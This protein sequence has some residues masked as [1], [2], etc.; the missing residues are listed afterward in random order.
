MQ[1][2]HFGGRGWGLIGGGLKFSGLLIK[3]FRSAGKNTASGCEPGWF[4][5][6]KSCHLFHLS[7]R[8]WG[9]ARSLCHSLGAELAVVNDVNTLQDLANQRREIKL[10]DRDFYLGL[11]GQLLWIWS[12]GE[13]VSNTHNLWGPNQPS[14]DGK[15]GTFLNAIRWDSNW[16]GYGWRWND[17][18]CTNLKGYIC[19]QPL[20]MLNIDGTM[21]R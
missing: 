18:S 14:G 19:Q 3:V 5:A 16:L 9:D 11:S 20:G 15:C 12:D 1:C 21:L 4:R 13:V 10:D 17:E 6:S 2:L 8:R 7:S